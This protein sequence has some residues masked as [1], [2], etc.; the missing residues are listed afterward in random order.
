[1]HTYA[2]LCG[3]EYYMNMNP[4]QIPHQTW[5][6]YA[7]AITLVALAAAMRIWP[8][9]A[10]ESTLA[11]LTFYP[12]VMV[13]AI[14]GGLFVGLLATVLACLTVTYMWPILVAQPFINHAA[15]WLGM[16]VFTLTGSMIS[17]VAEAMRR[18]QERAIKAKQQA[19]AANQ[20]KSVFLS[21]MSHELRTPLNAILGFSELMFCDPDLNEE[22]RVN[23]EI[24]NRSGKNLLYLINDVLDMAK[25]E[26]GWAILKIESFDISDLV[27]DIGDMLSNHAEEKGLQLIFE[28]FTGSLQFIK[29]DKEKLRQ[30][31]VN[32]LGNAIK[33][34]NHGSV[35]LRLRIQP[36]DAA[37][38][39]MIEVEDTGVGISKVDQAHIFDPFVQ[40]G[41]PSHHKGSGLG[42]S[43][44]R[45]YVNLMGGDIVV[46]STPDIGSL[47]R[48]SLPIQR[49]DKSDMISFEPAYGEVIRLEPGQ[50]DYR[51][52]I[53]EDQLENQL[54]LKLLLKEAGFTVEVANNGKEGVELFQSFHPHFIWMDR[55]M[56]VMNGIEATQR[57]RTM[58]GG[59]A[60]KI[61]AITA[62]AFVDQRDEILAAGMDDLVRKPYSPVELFNCMGRQL[63]VHFARE[64]VVHVNTTLSSSSLAKL[65]ETLRRA[66]SEGLILG[67]SEQLAKLIFRVEQQDATLAK[68][69]VRYVEA[70]NYLPILNALETVDTHN[71]QSKL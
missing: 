21:T 16:A 48:V 66:L 46:E 39:Q 5:T 15:D 33:Y 12:A 29:G 26:A 70:F 60:V 36:S 24:I 68:V 6:R 28:Q 31:I 59:K 18:A 52:L 10:L 51:I 20:A 64:Q 25:I 45:S 4:Q 58:A 56:P 30:V 44:V 61:A 71:K 32:L 38:L 9:Q 49:A 2:T 69:L 14:Y 27:R 43:I 65:P 67:D 42:L 3:R 23:I 63:G 11:W 50:P 1:M 57:I 37:M 34:T 53:V 55:N 54:L 17:G 40:V 62:S 13:A 22:Q 47:F 35:T 7:V 41:R 19:E 8:L